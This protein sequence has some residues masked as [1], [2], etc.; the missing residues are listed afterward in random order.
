MQRNTQMRQPSTNFFRGYNQIIFATFSLV[1]VVSSS[2]FYLQFRSRY[3]NE[4]EQ[5]QTKF[6]EEASSLNYLVKGASDHVSALQTQAESYLITHPVGEAPSSLFFQLENVP[7]KDYYG[8]DQVGSPFTENMVAGVSGRGSVESLSPEVKRELE[9]VFTLNP[10]FQSSKENIP[11]LAWV[12]YL[13]KNR[14]LSL[15]PWVS[16]SEYLL[17]EDDY[18]QDFYQL[19]LPENNPQRQLFW[20]RAYTDGAGKGLMVTVSVPV[21]DRDNFL[22]TVALDFTLDVLNDFI[23]ASEVE[24]DRPTNLFVLNQYDQLLAHPS[25]TN[26]TDAEVKS[27]QTAFPADLQSQYKQVLQIPVDRVSS[28]ESYLVLRHQLDN[29]P[30]QLILWVPKRKMV[31][32]ALSGTSWLFLVLLP[33]LGLI[34]FAANQFTRKEFIVPARRL[35]EHI[36][37]ESQGTVSRELDVPQTWQPWFEGISQIF[38]ENRNLLQTLESYT[39][40][41]EAKNATLQ[42]TENLLAE[43]NRNLEIQVEERTDQLQKV[44]IKLR[45]QTQDLENTLQELQQTQAQ[46]VQSEKMS[47][48][49]QLVAG[50]AHEINNPVNF[51][52]G[53]IAPAD[54]YVRDL[55]NLIS[56]YQE[57]YP[58]PFPAIQSEIEA[59]DLEFLVEDLPKLLTSMQIGADRIRQIVLSLRNFSRLDEAEFKAVDVHEGLDSTL[60][61]LENRLKAKPD[62]PAIEVI[63]EYDTLP[64]VDCYPGQLN[65]VF[66]NILTNAIDALVE[67]NTERSFQEI[68]ESPGCIHIRTRLI[69]SNRVAIKISDNGPGMSEEVK[70]HIFNPFFTTKPVGKGTGMGMSISYQIIIEKHS[71]SLECISFPGQGTEF[72]IEIPLQQT[73]SS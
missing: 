48:L 2:L 69:D 59:I 25:L 65:Q 18:S 32:N 72:V 9:M 4:V 57:Y 39:Q 30:W 37:N 56:L 19:G 10:L 27:A 43:H 53:N 40:A 16:S 52:Y 15:Y 8:L 38:A 63:K 20:T 23:K 3:Q 31:L 55:L 17:K 70:Q 11:N 5:L 42:E 54:G 62:C 26:S 50:V 44:I 68:Q 6:L 60:I 71:G 33:G 24:R 22:G 36:E 29:A 1:T 14:F 67:R 41:L 73:C 58:Q 7:E 28:V 64:L 47:S 51:I 13:S 34:L 12:Y 49:G 45:Q 61:I 35:V 21:Y 46:L 66:M